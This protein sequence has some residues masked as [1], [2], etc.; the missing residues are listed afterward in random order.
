MKVILIILGIFVYLVIGGVVSGLMDME[1]G[2]DVAC[3]FFWP[4]MVALLIIVGT[5]IGMTKLGVFISEYIIE[6]LT[7]VCEQLEICISGK[8]E[9]REDDN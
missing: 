4:L 9:E 3:V 6:A 7:P 8:E 2:S 5:G 1:D